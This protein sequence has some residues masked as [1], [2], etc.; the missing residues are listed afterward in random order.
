MGFLFCTKHSSKR[1]WFENWS[2][3]RGGGGGG[4]IGKKKKRKR[5]QA[6]GKMRSNGRLEREIETGIDGSKWEGEPEIH[7]FSGGIFS[8]C[9]CVCVYIYRAGGW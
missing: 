8:L 4:G 7:D 9:V 3:A 1:V 5:E 2:V 6:K